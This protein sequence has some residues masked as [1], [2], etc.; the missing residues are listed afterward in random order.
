MFSGSGR[1]CGFGFGSSRG[2]QV[3]QKLG[4]W[5]S[6]QTDTLQGLVIYSQYNCAFLF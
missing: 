3:N 2:K 5:L 6:L 1:T 4:R